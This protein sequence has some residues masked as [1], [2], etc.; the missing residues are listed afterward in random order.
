MRLPAAGSA[1]WCSPRALHAAYQTGR[2]P[3]PLLVSRN[4][5]EPNPKDDAAPAGNDGASWRLSPAPR[6]DMPSGSALLRPRPYRD[7]NARAPGFM[8]LYRALWNF[9]RKP[10]LGTH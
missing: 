10:D 5:L 9:E 1:V 4:G 8:T 3:L 6:P 7:V 2:D